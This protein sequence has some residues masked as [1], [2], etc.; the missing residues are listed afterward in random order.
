MQIYI[1]TGQNGDL[2]NKCLNHQVR[3]DLVLWSL[4]FEYMACH[5]GT[6]EAPQVSLEMG[7]FEMV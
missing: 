2:A 5:H 4:S 7:G 6:Y 1:Y 3:I